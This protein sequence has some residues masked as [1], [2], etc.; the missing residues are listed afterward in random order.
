LPFGPAQGITGR[1]PVGFDVHVYGE[2]R[3]FFAAFGAFAFVLVKDFVWRFKLGALV[4][5]VVAVVA[6]YSLRQAWS[7]V[8][9]ENKAMGGYLM[10]AKN[11]CLSSSGA[12]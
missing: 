2:Q 8:M 5:Y 12:L 10:I 1:L 9:K 7:P 3:E 4:E 11:P 6:D